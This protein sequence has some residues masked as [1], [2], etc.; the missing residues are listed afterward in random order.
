MHLFRVESTKYTNMKTY[1]SCKLIMALLG[2]TFLAVEVF[3]RLVLSNYIY[4][5]DLAVQ[6]SRYCA[7]PLNVSGHAIKTP[8]TNK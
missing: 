2:I 7:K 3:E 4:S 8:K 5:G 6:V 1:S